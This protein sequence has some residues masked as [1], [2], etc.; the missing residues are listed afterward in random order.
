MIRWTFFYNFRNKFTPT[1]SQKS[2][3]NTIQYQSSPTVKMYNKLITNWWT[4][5]KFCKL[6]FGSLAWR[7]SNILTINFYFIKTKQNKKIPTLIYV[8]YTT[9]INN[10]IVFADFGIN[11]IRSHV[12]LKENGVLMTF[13]RLQHRTAMILSY[14]SNIIR[15]IIHHT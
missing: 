13:D 5:I 4:T 11:P 7:C 3:Y 15:Y 12:H 1:N 2:S 8:L 10:I 6:R 14:D 9:R